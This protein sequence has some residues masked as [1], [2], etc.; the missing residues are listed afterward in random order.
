[1]S[2]S[3]NIDSLKNA[4]KNGTKVKAKNNNQTTIKIENLLPETDYHFNVVVEDKSGNEAVYSPLKHQTASGLWNQE[5][6]LKASNGDEEDYFGNSVA[7]SG[8][9]AVV[10][11]RYESSNQSSVTNGE[12]SSADNNATRAGAVYV[13][14][15]KG[16]SWIQEA[17]LKAPN[18]DALDYFGT[19]VAISGDT[20]VVGAPGESSNQNTVT[21]GS[22]ASSNNSATNS[23]AAYVFKRTGSTWAMEAYL[24]AANA[25]A[26]DAFGSSVAI[27]NDTVVVGAWGE[28]SNQTTITNGLSAS[29]DN[30]ASSAGLLTYL[31]GLESLGRRRLI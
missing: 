10:A 9:T 7:I 21:N 11:S 18:P 17:Y 23:G 22:T 6:F 16:T 20:I 30:S 28:S 5:V 14:R 31:S 26:N 8:D 2:N 25:D 24:E 1:M 13:Y 29:S 12:T 4:K 27:S 3:S 19:S 15:R